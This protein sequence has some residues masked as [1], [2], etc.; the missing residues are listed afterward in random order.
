VVLRGGRGMAEQTEP[1][2]RLD[3]PVLTDGPRSARSSRPVCALRAPR[4][5]GGRFIESMAASSLVSASPVSKI[6]R[7][8]QLSSTIIIPAA[9]QGS[10][11][12]RQT[13]EME[14]DR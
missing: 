9:L 8:V 10:Y 2:W 13:E 6:C 14:A 4:S 12:G 11:N 3:D 5:D 7:I 1:P